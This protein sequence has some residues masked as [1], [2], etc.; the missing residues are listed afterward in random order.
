MAKDPGTSF[1]KG[2]LVKAVK[3]PGAR[4]WDFGGWR[5]A[6]SEETREWYTKFH[7]DIRAGREV[8]HDDAGE[9]R[10]PPRDTYLEMVEGR[11]YQVVRG[12]VQAPCGYRTVKGAVELLCTHSG[13]RFYTRRGCIAHIGD[14]GALDGG[15]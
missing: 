11:I 6:S 13:E 12:R 4:S 15:Q 5:R 14:A 1:Y 10:L 8:W 9:S 2:Q 7:E 3:L